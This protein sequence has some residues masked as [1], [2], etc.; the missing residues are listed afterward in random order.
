MNVSII[1]LLLVTCVIVGLALAAA[2]GH[3]MPT[4]ICLI[5]IMVGA[6]VVLAP[7][8]FSF[9]LQLFGREGA[10]GADHGMLGG[11]MVFVGIVGSIFSRRSTAMPPK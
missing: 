5:L 11:I 10:V 2:R 4:G 3:T 9:L 1:Y 8:I 7:T 6:F